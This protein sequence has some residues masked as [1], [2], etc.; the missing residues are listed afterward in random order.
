M[1]E[2]PALTRARE[3]RLACRAS[4][5]RAGWEFRRACAGAASI[6][7]WIDEGE[8]LIRLGS[9][10]GGP[11]LGVVSLFSPGKKSAG[12][13]LGLFGRVWT[14]V[15]LGLRIQEAWSRRSR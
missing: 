5:R 7:Y 15:Q 6:G 9:Q 2:L 11:I 14:A 10:W 1:V 12:H 4:S 3:I 13:A 8:N